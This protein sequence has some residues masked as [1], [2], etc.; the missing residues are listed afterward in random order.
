MTLSK[1]RVYIRTGEHE[2][3]DQCALLGMNAKTVMER[4]I[5]KKPSF[6]MIDPEKLT[7][8]WLRTRMV[9][10]MSAI[11]FCQ[12]TERRSQDQLVKECFVRYGATIEE[13]I[14]AHLDLI[15]EIRMTASV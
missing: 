12:P 9:E 2:I 10:S 8:E 15:A 5:G 7:R 1:F 6:F 3:K 4:L 11:L 14:E 13:F